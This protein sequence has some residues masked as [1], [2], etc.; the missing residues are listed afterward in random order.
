[1]TSNRALDAGRT[2]FD[3]NAWSEAFASLTAADRAEPLA[4]EDL[5]RLATAAYLAGEHAA[6]LEARARAHGGFIE[7][8][9][10]ARAARSAFW[11][12]FALQDDAH[13]QAQRAGWI[14]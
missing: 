4:P 6:G 9:E 14:A 1:M 10:P 2:A 11:F 12:A 13:Q 3:R 5:D 7:R 8:G